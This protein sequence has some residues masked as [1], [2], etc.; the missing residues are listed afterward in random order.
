MIQF[1]VCTDGRGRML[2]GVRAVV[3]FRRC[4]SGFT[5]VELLAV[6]S[7]I[8]ILIG[9]LLPA[10]QAAREAARLT[11]CRNNLK[12]IAA[13]VQ[14][15]EATN[16]YFPGHGGEA[17]PMDAVF[18]ADHA[19]QARSMPVTGSWLMQ[20]CN[21]MEAGQITDAMLRA[22]QR[23]A[24]QAEAAVAV[25]TPIPT[26]Y[27]PTR[28]ARIAY[29]LT[30]SEASA[31]GVKIGGRTDYA[32]NAGSGTP[33]QGSFQGEQRQGTR[34]D[35]DGIWS[36]GRQ[37]TAA[38]VA[39]GLSHTYLVG[40]KAMDPRQYTTGLDHGDRARQPVWPIAAGPQILTSA[41]PHAP[42]FATWSRAATHA[43]TLAA[44]I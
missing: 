9:L 33:T 19:R 29:P 30:G 23:R 13:A 12:Q 21:Y 11:H 37:I 36:Y 1:A 6:I 28:R 10:I 32:M 14:Q 4:P 39:D 41:L 17:Q 43:M 27:C 22:A 25:A 2:R 18:D 5:L 7:I 8:A 3:Y 15:F 20:A 26:L 16:R 38:N 42:R 24:T 40:E 35:H 44:R 31:W 34:I